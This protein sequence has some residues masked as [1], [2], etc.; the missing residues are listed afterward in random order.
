MKHIYIYI[1]INYVHQTPNKHRTPYSVQLGARQNSN[2]IGG[3]CQY[4]V[5]DKPGQQQQLSIGIGIGAARI[6]E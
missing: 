2:S 6:V 3:Q 5:S 1:Y 4:S